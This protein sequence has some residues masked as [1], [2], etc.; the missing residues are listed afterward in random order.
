MAKELSEGVRGQIM[1]LIKEGLS[2]RQIATRMRVSKGAEQGT[3]ERFKRTNAYT[4]RYQSL[5]DQSV[6]HN[7]RIGSSRLLLC[8]I[9]ERL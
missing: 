9:E 8:V 3:A 6:L 1:G 2:H 5:E 4:P 7:N